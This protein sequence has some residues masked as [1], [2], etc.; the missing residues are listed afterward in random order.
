MFPTSFRKSLKKPWHQLVEEGEVTAFRQ[1]W[2][3]Q[4]QYSIERR[5]LGEGWDPIYVIG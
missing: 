2:Q 5:L 1:N 3:S 4:A